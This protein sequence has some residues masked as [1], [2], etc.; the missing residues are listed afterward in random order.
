[1]NKEKSVKKQWIGVLAVLI[2]LCGVLLCL[3]PA[4]NEVDRHS[5][6][7]S[8]DTRAF[9]D[10]PGNG[11]P[12]G[13]SQFVSGE[14]IAGSILVTDPGDIHDWYYIDVP[15][16]NVV[17][18]SMFQWQHNATNP[19]E[20]N[21]QILLGYFLPTDVYW[22][23]EG[24]TENRWEAAS[25]YTPV[26]RT[27]HIVVLS[28]QTEGDI[29]NSK[30]TNYTL[31]VSLSLPYTINRD[32]ALFTHVDTSWTHH[33][34]IWCRLEPAPEPDELLYAYTEFDDTADVDLFFYT[35]W[36]Y[37]PDFLTLMN[38]SR[39][40]GPHISEYLEFGGAEGEFF[41]RL[42]TEA[43]EGDI[44]FVIRNFSKTRDDDN[45]MDRANIISDNNEMHFAIDQGVDHYD[46]FA[47]DMKAGEAITKIRFKIEKGGWPLYRVDILNETGAV[48]HFSYNTL[49]GTLPRDDNPT[50]VGITFRNIQAGYT[51]RHYVVVRIIGTYNILFDYGYRPAWGHYSLTFTLPNNPPEVTAALP[52]VSIQEDS[53]YTGIDLDDHF[54]DPDG[55]TLRFSLGKMTQNTHVEIDQDTGILTII[56][57]PN[58][59]GQEVVVIR[60]TDDGPGKKFVETWMT[61]EVEQRNDAP[62]IISGKSIAN[63]TMYEDQI[64]HTPAMSTIFNDPDNDGGKPLVYTI[65]LL[66]KNLTPPDAKL[67]L[68]TY[69]STTDTFDI[70]PM[71]RMFG[72]AKFRIRADDR[73]GTGQGSLPITEFNLSIIHVNHAPR[74]RSGVKDKVDITLKEGEY[75]ET[76][77]IWD[78]VEDEDTAYTNDTLS[79]SLAGQVFL[80]AGIKES[81]C[82]WFDA[83]KEFYPG[84]NYREDIVVTVTDSFDL[85]VMVNFSVTVLPEDDPPVVDST[86]PDQAGS[87]TIMEGQKREFKVLVKDPDTPYK[88]INYT[89]HLDGV[90][91]ENWNSSLFS[92]STDYESADG[93]EHILK[94]T[95]T[96]GLH[97]V[98]AQWVVTITDMNRAPRE[99]AILNPINSSQFEK[100][101]TIELT[102]DA[103]DPDE[104]QLTY[105]WYKE[106]KVL[107][108]G[109]SFKAEDLEPGIH[110]VTLEVSDG[111]YSTNSTAVFEVV[112]P[113]KEEGFPGFEAWG[114]MGVMAFAGILMLLIRKKR[115]WSR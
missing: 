81:G 104:D 95:I 60:A 89:W 32:S 33:T 99:V 55:D 34:D 16:G 113:E 31:S 69:N 66:E 43:G 15:A 54:S 3:V 57:E 13:A 1:M 5:T 100:G 92:Y 64:V 47:V 114:V 9:D 8:K 36:P 96:S 38:L 7:E 45:V 51:G 56:P 26:D 68:P 27:F 28:N 72:I 40:K 88:D 41:L 111:E 87:T 50:T 6:A 109:K 59:F 58:W 71:D 102:G 75:N 23:D 14:I 48:L 30:P 76:C 35:V 52:L 101:E 65:S 110:I 22:A 108:T 85:T 79:Y 44:G 24:W 61:V 86:N 107:G 21:L 67:P 4:W 2:M 112:R 63:I 46:W 39:T 17:N 90:I 25:Y 103:T 78:Y 115:R 29:P 62:V 94:V 19:S 82:I 73:N 11:D 98:Q 93:K 42:T 91:Q 74:L 49:D 10:E 106:G 80:E 70:G 12:G 105:T 53:D 18:V 20:Y 83:S 84:Q 97:E 77:F 37:E